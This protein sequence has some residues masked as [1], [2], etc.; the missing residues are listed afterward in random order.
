MLEEWSSL[1]LELERTTGGY[2]PPVAARMHGYIGLGAYLASIKDEDFE[3][4]N[5]FMQSM[6]HHVS[7]DQIGM[8]AAL[9]VNS[10]YARLAELF[11][12]QHH[13]N[14]SLKLKNLNLNS[15]KIKQV[16][17]SGS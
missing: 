13:L 3:D 17:R 6:K 7:L 4:L 9:S 11:L 14:S 5:C 2:R 12:L 10:S 1:I 15:V 16:G 8:D